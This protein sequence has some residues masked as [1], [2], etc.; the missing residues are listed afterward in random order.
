VHTRRWRK[1]KSRPANNPG[2]KAVMGPH[3]LALVAASRARLQGKRRCGAALAPLI[4]V[5]A[6]GRLDREGR[7][8]RAMSGSKENA[9]F[10]AIMAI[11]RDR[12]QPLGKITA[13]RAA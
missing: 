3:G 10:E 8:L 5:V 9:S 7:G 4:G 1:P 2:D 11:R 12:L 13:A 6:V